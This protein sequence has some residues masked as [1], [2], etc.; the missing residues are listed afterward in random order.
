[1]R[2]RFRVRV[3]VSVGRRPPAYRGESGAAVLETRDLRLLAG[4]RELLLEHVVP[5]QYLHV[6]PAQADA[7]SRAQPATIDAPEHLVCVLGAAS[8]WVTALWRLPGCLA[9]A[10]SCRSLRRLPLRLARPLV[11]VVRRSAHL[12][13]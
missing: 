11:V 9:I 1:M 13:D 12:V 8:L 7:A 2:A 3:G 5:T 6:V 4:D 10:L